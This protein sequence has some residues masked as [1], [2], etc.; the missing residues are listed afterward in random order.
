MGSCAPIAKTLEGVTRLDFYGLSGTCGTG[1]AGTDS[2]LLTT[3][4]R[5]EIG[6]K[7]DIQTITHSSEAVDTPCGKK[8]FHASAN[9]TIYAKVDNKII[10]Y[11][12]AKSLTVGVLKDGSISDKIKMT[13]SSSAAPTYTV[14]FPASNTFSA[15]LGLL[16]SCGHF[17]F[18]AKYYEETVFTNGWGAAVF[19]LVPLSTAGASVTFEEDVPFIPGF[20][21]N[22]PNH[23]YVTTGTTGTLFHGLAGNSIYA[24]S[25]ML[26]ENSGTIGAFFIQILGRASESY[27]PAYMR[28]STTFKVAWPAIE[29][30]G[31]PNPLVT[32]QTAFSIPDGAIA[33]CFSADP[34]VYVVRS[35][36]GTV[37]QSI[38]QRPDQIQEQWP[39]EGC[40]ACSNI[41]IHIDASGASCSTEMRADV[42][43]LSGVHGLACE[44]CN[45]ELKYWSQWLVDGT[46]AYGPY[47]GGKWP[48]IISKVSVRDGKIW[49]MLSL[50]D[51]TRT[52][53]VIAHYKS[54]ISCQRPVDP[55]RPDDPAAG[56]NFFDSALPH[57]FEHHGSTV[58]R[59]VS[60]AINKGMLLPVPDDVPGICFFRDLQIT[61]MVVGTQRG[62]ISPSSCCSRDPIYC[63]GSQF[64]FKL[65]GA[66]VAG[67]VWM[68]DSSM[69]LYG[70]S[71]EDILG[72]YG[73][74]LTAADIGRFHASDANVNIPVFVNWVSNGMTNAPPMT[75]AL[76]ASQSTLV[77]Q[78]A[79][80]SKTEC[81]NPTRTVEGGWTATGEL[82]PDDYK[83][84]AR[85]LDHDYLARRYTNPPYGMAWLEMPGTGYFHVQP[86]VK[87]TLAPYFGRPTSY[88]PSQVWPSGYPNYPDD[89]GWVTPSVNVYQMGAN[90]TDTVWGGGGSYS[91]GTM[92]G[93]NGG[94]GFFFYPVLGTSG[95]NQ[96]II[97]RTIPQRT[98][99]T[100][101]SSVPLPG[102]QL[103]TAISFP[104]YSHMMWHGGLKRLTVLP[105]DD[106]PEL[107]RDIGTPTAVGVCVENF[108][109]KGAVTFFE[110]TN[111]NSPKYYGADWEGACARAAGAAPCP[112]NHARLADQSCVQLP[113][114]RCRAGTLSGSPCGFGSGTT[115]LTSEDQIGQ[116]FPTGFGGR[117]AFDICQGTGG[118]NAGGKTASATYHPVPVVDGCAAYAAGNIF[119]WSTEP[120]CIADIRLSNP[121]GGPGGPCPGC[122]DGVYPFGL[123]IPLQDRRTFYTISVASSGYFLGPSGGGPYH[124]CGVELF[125]ISQFGFGGNYNP[126]GL[127]CLDSVSGPFDDGHSTCG[128]NPE[129]WN[130]CRPA[131]TVINPID[132]MTSCPECNV[133]GVVK[134][135]YR[136]NYDV[137]NWSPGQFRYAGNEDGTLSVFFLYTSTVMAVRPWT[138]EITRPTN[139]PWFDGTTLSVN[140]CVNTCNGYAAKKECKNCATGATATWTLKSF[141][142]VFVTRVHQVE[143]R[144]TDPFVPCLRPNNNRAAQVSLAFVS[145]T[146][147]HESIYSTS[148]IQ[149][150]LIVDLEQQIASCGNITVTEDFPSDQPSLVPDQPLVDYSFSTM[151]AMFSQYSASVTGYPTSYKVSMGDAPDNLED[152]PSPA[153]PLPDCCSVYTGEHTLVLEPGNAIWVDETNPLCD[154]LTPDGNLLIELR[155]PLSGSAWVLEFFKNEPN[156]R[157]RP[158][159]RY[160]LNV[161]SKTPNWDINGRNLMVLNDY[162]PTCCRNWPRYVYV[163]PV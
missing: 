83:P 146:V 143:W 46:E 61:G 106:V 151:E 44:N 121:Q 60:P 87:P 66:T 100:F 138:V 62:G 111:Q 70:R 75:S 158:I 163:E 130:D 38:V 57:V 65:T 84:Y 49:L 23:T 117:S 35:V 28:L 10:G 122:Y 157:R 76:F 39:L 133:P 77:G 109:C 53:G 69:S 48:P 25:E 51:S 58:Y 79:K 14:S 145:D 124:S 149:Q 1:C 105:G 13:V 119:G 140:P 26:E 112:P 7:P 6:S 42:E 31:G 144:T 9:T 141:K 8:S 24:D 102:K 15:I 54:E 103:N 110:A 95:T 93:A 108:S 127:S 147:T 97:D 37:S 136:R 134:T 18:A 125:G 22:P 99:P 156:F 80:A 64:E 27:S 137:A 154:A 71:D 88:D 91:I 135:K 2:A 19:V 4:R 45:G 11:K 32:G 17:A 56:P 162:D 50:I 116:G 155:M 142:R 29:V 114:G 59:M 52:Y 85:R 21:Y 148:R 160:L 120:D 101:G 73:S 123:P 98:G 139:L 74:A 40:C 33:G 72:L 152:P 3:I 161:C 78:S 89:T 82:E 86:V 96:D 68:N 34:S 104:S 5:D 16:S 63:P 47:G 131:D 115:F 92:P 30:Y 153:P 126:S 107:I 36:A 132:R 41:G 67:G 128:E 55:D 90:V 150:G 94:A 20:P 43:G 81:E 129:I 12:R 113:I 159:A 118:C